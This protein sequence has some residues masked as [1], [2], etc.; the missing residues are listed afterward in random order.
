MNKEP[1]SSHEEN[2]VPFLAAL[3]IFLSAVEYAV[4]KPLP[5]M[6]LGLANLPII[7]A[8]F[9][10]NA[11]QYFL[12]V[13]VKVLGQSIVSGTLFSYI[14]LFSAGGTLAS[15]LAMFILYRIFGRYVSC[16]GLSLLGALA[17]NSVQLILA[18]WILFGKGAFFLA[19]LLYTAG[20]VTGVLLGFFALAFTSSSRW[21]SLCRTR[22]VPL[23][24]ETLSIDADNLFTGNSGQKKKRIKILPPLLV[25]VSIVFFS[26]LQPHGKVL[27]SFFSL[28]ITSG[29]LISGLRKAFILT[30]MVVLSRLFIKTSFKLPGKPGLFMNRVFQYLGLLTQ[31]HIKKSRLRSIIKAVDSRLMA[32][33]FT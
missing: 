17:N 8:L 7:L 4:P 13:F 10:L 29:A 1:Y 14:V 24:T 3:C 18:R 11:R 6:R 30:A 31:K 2:L 5:F 27:V 28:D 12:L 25:F 20:A 23:E 9:L 19:P 21:F 15:S 32:V 22:S 26:L 16:I 33:Y